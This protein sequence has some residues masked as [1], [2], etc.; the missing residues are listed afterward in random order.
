[1]TPERKLFQPV[2]SSDVCEIYEL[3]RSN[4]LI[5]FPLT[6]EARHKIEAIVST[7][8]Q[9]HYDTEIYPTIEEKAFA[10]LFFLIKDHPFT[11]GNK[12]TAT[13]T[14]S[15]V[16]TLNGLEENPDFPLDELAVFIEKIKEEDHHMVI[17]ALAQTY[18]DN[19]E[20]KSGPA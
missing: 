2:T 18:F 12:R 13:F 8:T 15:V 19:G 1:M 11:D 5:S 17:R 3:L 7:I 4:G 16:C 20:S 10:Y 9:T 14:F 6:N